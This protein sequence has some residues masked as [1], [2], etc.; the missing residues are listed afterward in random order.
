MMTSPRI[1]ARAIALVA[2]LG[3]GQLAVGLDVTGVDWGFDG[4]LVP[5]AFNPVT[6]DVIND[7]RD[8][9][10]G[11]VQLRIGDSSLGGELPIVESGLYLLPGEV[12]RIRFYPFISE[13][14]SSAAL[15][16]GNGQKTSLLN[17]MQQ[18]RYG[19]P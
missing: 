11:E 1:I 10:E 16:W 2:A 6:V 18:V 5:M 9:F 13:L 12:R 8:T 15:E 4:K 7:G 17:D 3:V 14:P 19:Q